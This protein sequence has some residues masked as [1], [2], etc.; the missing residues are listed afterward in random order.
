M[1]C[2]LRRTM[3]RWGASAS[4]DSS[5]FK[6]SV[7]AEWK[8]GDGRAA[9]LLLSDFNLMVNDDAHT[10]EWARGKPCNKL[11][12][13]LIALNEW[14]CGKNIPAIHTLISDDDTL[15]KMKDD[16]AG[17][18]YVDEN[19]KVEDFAVC[20]AGFPA[21][22]GVWKQALV[23]VPSGAFLYITRISRDEHTV[24]HEMHFVIFRSGHA[25]NFGWFPSVSN[26]SPPISLQ[27][28]LNVYLCVF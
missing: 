28:L 14:C 22:C 20:A 4:I 17:D 16:H 7:L 2:N 3:K 8:M 21:L 12:L 1:P 9:Y 5:H 19:D 25:S 24:F 26:F 18:N 15:M 13:R 27:F 11:E 6:M 10:R 23:L